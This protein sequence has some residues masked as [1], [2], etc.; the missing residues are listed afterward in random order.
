MGGHQDGVA[1]DRTA[2][3]GVGQAEHRGLQRSRSPLGG[4]CIDGVGTGAVDRSGRDR[5]DELYHRRVN[6]RSGDHKFEVVDEP[7]PGKV[8]THRGAFLEF[9]LELHFGVGDILT[10]VK[11]LDLPP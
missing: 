11:G 4:F 3:R 8:G 2:H 1:D 7:A 9:E 5:G 6:L 10:H